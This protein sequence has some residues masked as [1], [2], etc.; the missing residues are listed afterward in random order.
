MLPTTA[1]KLQNFFG[2]FLQSQVDVDIAIMCSSG[3]PCFCKVGM[4][5]VRSIF[6]IE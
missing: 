1:E 5:V 2:V 6:V 4:G 3:R